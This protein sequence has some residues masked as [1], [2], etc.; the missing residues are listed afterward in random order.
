MI[1]IIT[2][3]IKKT[4]MF[5]RCTY[6]STDCYWLRIFSHMSKPA[7]RYTEVNSTRQTQPAE[8][9]E[10]IFKVLLCPNNNTREQCDGNGQKLLYTS[11][12]CRSTF[13]RLV[14]F[15]PTHFVATLRCARCTANICCVQRK[16]QRRWSGA[17]VL[18]W[19]LLANRNDTL[20]ISS[21]DM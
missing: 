3:N 4:Q 15:F 2:K 11:Y 1:R 14:A 8:K 5:A 20:H 12:C 10:T 19:L 9:I 18:C 17:A 7:N 13:F 21:H 6:A 16:T